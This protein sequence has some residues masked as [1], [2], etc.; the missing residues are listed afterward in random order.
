MREMEDDPAC[1]DQMND[2][3]TD[4]L[5]LVAKVIVD[6][7]PVEIDCKGHRILLDSYLGDLQVDL[8]VDLK[9]AES[10]RTGW[11]KVGQSIRENDAFCHM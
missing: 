6:Q 4:P 3:P 7:G 9:K 10:E 8:L 5:T 11:G 1:W 2:S